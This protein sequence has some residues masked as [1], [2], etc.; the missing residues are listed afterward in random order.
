VSDRPWD[1]TWWEY[2]AQ[3]GLPTSVEPRK[4]ERGAYSYPRTKRP[5]RDYFADEDD[6]HLEAP[7][8]FDCLSEGYLI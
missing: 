2:A 8:R 5:V 7:K 1:M 4:I 3:Q 6:T